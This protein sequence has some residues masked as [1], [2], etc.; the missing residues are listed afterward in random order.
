MFRQQ[1]RQ[2]RMKRCQDIIC[3]SDEDSQ[4]PKSRAKRPKYDRERD[5][6][7]YYSDPKK[8]NLFMLLPSSPFEVRRDE[9]EAPF[10]RHNSKVRAI[11]A[12]R[13]QSL[14]TS[15][16]PYAYL[17]LHHPNPPSPSWHLHTVPLP[18]SSTFHMKVKEVAGEVVDSCSSNTDDPQYTDDD[19]LSS[20]ASL[21]S[22]DD[23]DMDNI[24]A[25]FLHFNE[26]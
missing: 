8:P 19:I 21:A 10:K 9:Q 26:E 22:Y 12:P 1:Q 3:D 15:P 23:Q 4:S 2:V 25:I 24:E 11:L 18:L 17:P 5:L 14:F 7:G 13:S 6:F 20:L 16:S